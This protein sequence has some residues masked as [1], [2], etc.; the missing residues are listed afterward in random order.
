MQT[1][2]FLTISIILVMGI[3][4]ILS[5]SSVLSDATIFSSDLNTC[6]I[7]D[8]HLI[9]GVPHVSQETSF[10]CLLAS[11]T[12]IFKYYG[13]N[14]TLHEVLYNSGVGYSL[15]YP[16]PFLNRLPACGSQVSGSTADRS[17]LASL[18]GL[19]YEKWQ[20]NNSLTNDKRWQEYWVKVKQ[21]ISEDIPVVTNVD[22]FYL[23]Y[24]NFNKKDSII[25]DW[26]LEYIPSSGGHVIVLV[27]F[28]ESNETVCYNDPAS[29]LWGKPS[30]GHY[31]WMDINFLKKAVSEYPLPYSLGIFRNTSKD[32]LS[33]EEIIEKAYKR[34]IEKLKGNFSAYN[35]S[36][37]EEFFENFW[38]DAKIG[39]NASNA[40]K[41]D[42]ERGIQNR[43]K[44][45]LTYKLDGKKGI[46]NIIIN[47]LYPYLF[48]V[49]NIPQSLCEVY[50]QY[51]R[52]K[53]VEIDKRYTAEYLKENIDINN[54]I[55]FEAILFEHEAENW[56]KL[57]SYYSQFKKKGIF[58]SLPR[59]I[60]L[61]NKMADTMD[62]IIA[63]EEAIIAGPSED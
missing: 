37:Y 14:T 59:A 58:M 42:F 6:E 25:P 17:F 38:D 39:V 41:K 1:R 19:S 20:A 23:D 48:S 2:K 63:I 10:Y 57:A 53:M 22:T 18:Y 13:I 4:P 51:D 16:I 9:E 32:P 34:N 47:R 27:G 44:T 31:N 36:E 33:H 7:P 43:F 11:P 52:F 21:N 55:A 8:S 3:T 12:M 46:R 61:M 26:L 29:P 24:Y 30:E 60:L 5:S 49:L 15:V 45:I 40:L 62:N 54:S 50:L 56:S 35:L 28:N